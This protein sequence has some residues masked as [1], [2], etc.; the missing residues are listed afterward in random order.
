MANDL[1]ATRKERILKKNKS[2]SSTE[3]S[4]DQL[5]HDIL[6]TATMPV[7]VPGFIVAR[8]SDGLTMRHKRGAGSS[9]QIVSTFPNSNV[10]QVLGDEGEYGSVI[11]VRDAV[12]LELKGQLVE[13]HGSTIIATDVTTGEQTHLNSGVQGV[14][15]AMTVDEASAAKK[16]ANLGKKK[17]AKKAA[18]PAAKAKKAKK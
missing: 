13:V 16:Y 11:V 3:V 10:V 12:V 17:T 2:I 18:K 7:E 15:I 9:K 6:V 14:N 5:P 8:T 1:V 4:M